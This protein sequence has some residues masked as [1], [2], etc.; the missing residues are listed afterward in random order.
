[1][2]NLISRE[3][4]LSWE[5]EMLKTWSER[6]AYYD[7]RIDRAFLLYADPKTKR[8]ADTY[9]MN[10]GE[11]SKGQTIIFQMTSDEGPFRNI[12]TVSEFIEQAELLK[13]QDPFTTLTLN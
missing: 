1:M 12:E 13:N 11:D 9:V 10:D 4:F 8:L 6:V 3:E 2:A 7:P 5:N